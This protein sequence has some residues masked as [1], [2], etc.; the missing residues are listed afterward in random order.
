DQAA[1][2]EAV[3]RRPDRAWPESRAAAVRAP[4]RDRE[5]HADPPGEGST[6]SSA[7]TSD[8]PPGPAQAAARHSRRH[9]DRAPGTTRGNSEFGIWNLEFVRASHTFWHAFQIPNSEC[10]IAGSSLSLHRWPPDARQVSAWR[11]G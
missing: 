1:A 10:Q 11:T 8:P 9:K 6:P 4:A 5:G 3:G 7:R 2:G